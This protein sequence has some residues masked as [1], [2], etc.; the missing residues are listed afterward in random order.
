MV[1]VVDFAKASK[2]FT[3]PD[4]FLSFLAKEK[5]LLLRQNAN[6]ED[7]AVDL[8]LAANKYQAC[9]PAMPCAL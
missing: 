7:V 4:D 9:R 6:W 3:F 5:G 1:D 8:D 2:A